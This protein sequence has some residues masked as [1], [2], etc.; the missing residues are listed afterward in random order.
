MRMIR[1]G[2]QYINLERCRVDLAYRLPVF[3]KSTG[4]HE[5][6]RVIRIYFVGELEGSAGDTATNYLQITGANYE[7]VR[8]WL[9][10]MLRGMIVGEIDLDGAGVVPARP[11]ITSLFPEL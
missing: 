5:D 4:R 1:I 3:D 10:E 6:R 9:E 11:L 8:A 7:P 2:N